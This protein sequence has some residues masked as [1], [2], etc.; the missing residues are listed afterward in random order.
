MNGELAQ[1]VALTAHGNAALHGPGTAVE[2]AT[3]NSTFRFVN[4]VQFA[5]PGSPPAHHCLA[6]WAGLRLR[7]IR[8]LLL[9]RS[10]PRSTMAGFSEH[11]QVAFAGG[12]AAGILAL[13]DGAG[14][15]WA[16]R[17][18]VT[19]PRNRNQ[20]IWTVS[21]VGQSATDIDNPSTTLSTAVP[22]LARALEGIRDFAIRENLE[23][24]I[25][26]FTE[27][28]E[29]LSS[30]DPS[31]PHHPDLL[32]TTGYSLASRQ[33]LSAATRGWVFGGMGSWNDLTPGDQT[34][35]D[36]ITETYFEAVMKAVVA[37]VNAFQPG[38][39]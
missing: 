20:Q 30:P 12:L 3:T 26:W 14:E 39:P 19:Q 4:D 28:L 9:T 33:I 29:L 21:Y 17:W 34:G 23:F 13:G 16:A 18:E 6:W 8:R 27:A 35:Y 36:G 10:R 24:W 38:S 1:L 22:E 7:G 32:P 2:L 5:F 31:P 11:H 15:R 37:A 25:P